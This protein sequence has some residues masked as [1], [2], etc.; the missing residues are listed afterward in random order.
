MEAGEEQVEAPAKLHNQ[1]SDESSAGVLRI[2][3]VIG[4]AY[5]YLIAGIYSVPNKKSQRKHDREKHSG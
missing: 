1:E 3:P 2:I 4:D 5:H